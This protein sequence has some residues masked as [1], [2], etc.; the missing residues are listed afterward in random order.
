[1]DAY[2]R[3]SSIN[4]KFKRRGGIMAGISLA[5]AQGHVR[6]SNNDYYSIHD[7]HA[8][9]R[10]TIYLKIRVSCYWIHS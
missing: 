3:A 1:M 10:S 5:E 7:L 6:L 8:D 9:R 4:I 2:R